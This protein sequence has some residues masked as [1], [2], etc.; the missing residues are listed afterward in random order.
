[1]LEI[2]TTILQMF[3]ARTECFVQNLKQLTQKSETKTRITKIFETIQVFAWFITWDLACC[4]QF[5][6]VHPPF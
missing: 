4:V 6:R 2:P 1:M 3:K 5:L